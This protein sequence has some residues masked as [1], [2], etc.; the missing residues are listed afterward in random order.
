[1]AT[2]R[3][4]STVTRAILCVLA[5]ALVAL[6]ATVTVASPAS[7]ETVSATGSAVVV[8]SFGGSTVKDAAWRAL[9]D[10]CLTGAT[11]APSVSSSP[12]VCALRVGSPSA[13]AATGYLQLT[14]STGYRKG[15]AV[16]TA[17]SASALGLEVTFDQWQYGTAKY[18]GDG[19]TFFIAD[20]AAT[21]TSP[22]GLG[23]SLGYAQNTNQPP[24]PNGIAGAYLGVG[25]DVHGNFAASGDGHGS[26]CTTGQ[27]A[28]PKPNSVVL[29][30]PGSGKS[31][32]CFLTASSLPTATQNLHVTVTDPGTVTTAMAR[33]FRV[34]VSPDRYPTVTVYAALSADTEPKQVLQYKMTDAAPESY[35]F[36]FT[37]ASGSTVGTHLIGN[38]SA[39][40]VTRSDTTPPAITITGGASA[41][42]AT[43]TPMVSGTTDAD[44]GSTMTVLLGSQKLS[45]TVAADGTWSVTPGALAEGKTTVSVS[46]TDAAGNTGTATQI[47]TV[48][49][50][51]P[52]IAIAGG[53]SASSTSATPM[54]TGR[55]DA[56]EGSIVNVKISDQVLAAKVLADGTWSLTPAPLDNGT[57][58]ITA[59]TTDQA[60]NIGTAAQKMT[61]AVAPSITIS[62]GTTALT[63]QPRP[64]VS[65]T[66]TAVAGRTATVTVDGQTLTATIAAT[67][68]WSVVP[69]TLTH[70]AHRITAVVSAVNGVKVTSSQTLTVD[71]IAPAIVI[72]GGSAISTQ[73]NTA[74]I[75]G[76]ID[77]PA[78]SKIKVVLDDVAREVVVSATRTWS[79]TSPA[80]KAGAHTV[81]VS[82]TDAAGNVGTQKQRITVI[83]VLSI[84]GGAARLTNNP[85]P[86]ISGTTDAPAGT[87]VTVTVAGQ[88]LTGKVTAAG[89]WTVTP[90]SLTST[91][92]SAKATVR[93]AVGNVRTA[94]QNLTVDTI[95]PSIVI[96]GGSAVS[97]KSATPTITG[98]VNV[99]AGSKMKIV[100]DATALDAVVSATRTWSVTSPRIK[101][102]A[103]TVAASA[104]DAAGNVGTVKQRLTVVG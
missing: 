104:T 13:K 100:V 81:V 77:V 43:V 91:T 61:I 71:T 55:T 5:P 94:W 67:G 54:V 12:G 42:T 60:G 103:H 47:L 37:A 15:G 24:A 65:G 84:D 99:P 44:A 90:S 8:E 68:A 62:G 1:M 31:G 93:D 3:G 35:Q 45:A 59:T 72:N 76:R 97:T 22:G 6:G 33:T 48:D 63:N 16:Y 86:T 27:S 57:V 70:G 29:R 25:L 87:Q 96:D 39:S 69:T 52:V 80:L 49:T 56:P 92:Y 14:D 102:G 73:S 50:I 98:R 74:T 53:P 79:V 17:A 58:P 21:V 46:A 82:A 26:G 40:T 75:S 51:A 23:S 64:P 95:A 85:T 19:V 83:P 38:V 88:T 78:G 7:A 32:Y 36:G 2:E 28:T 10:A 101:A 11:V 18:G 20:G 30:G 9:G 89:I 41:Y 4:R 34:T 66:S